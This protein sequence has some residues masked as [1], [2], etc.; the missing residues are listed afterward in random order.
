[1]YLANKD[2]IKKETGVFLFSQQ[3]K[4]TYLGKAENIDKAK[5][6]VKEYSENKP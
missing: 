6:A 4:M 1:M 2:R 3:A 5:E